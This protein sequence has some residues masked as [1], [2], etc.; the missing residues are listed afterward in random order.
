MGSL[1]LFQHFPKSNRAG[2]WG[3]ILE[4]IMRHYYYVSFSFTNGRGQHGFGGTEIHCNKKITHMNGIEEITSLI[5]K[6]L[7]NKDHPNPG[8]VVLNLIFLREEE[9]A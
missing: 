9:L 3:K 7:V 8:I 4:I 1:E 2:C 6:G 5:G